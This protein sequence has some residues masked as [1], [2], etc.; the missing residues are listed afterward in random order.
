MEMTLILWIVKQLLS[1][2]LSEWQWDT[3]SW[4]MNRTLQELLQLAAWSWNNFQPVVN[5]HYWYLIKKPCLPYHQAIELNSHGERRH[6][7]SLT[8]IR[9]HSCASTAICLLKSWGHMTDL[10]SR[11]RDNLLKHGERNRKYFNVRLIWVKPFMFHL[12]VWQVT[13]RSK[14]EHKAATSSFTVSTWAL[15]SSGRFWDWF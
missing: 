1:K 7:C 4:T 5:S 10:H 2:E 11:E 6:R 13:N 8:A 3:S 9:V 14:H 15:K 12:S